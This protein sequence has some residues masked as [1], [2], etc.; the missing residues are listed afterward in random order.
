MDETTRDHRSALTA[1]L[2]AAGG[3]G[4]AFAAAVCCSLPLTLGALGIAGGAWMLD[5]A[6]VVGPWQRALLWSATALLFGA[7]MVG[8]CRVAGASGP[9]C[10][11][12]IL[13]AGLTASIVAGI[14][15]VWLSLTVG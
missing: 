8:M 10:T 9:V 13:R 14:G 15:F 11:S 3:V 1:I 5:V 6:F 12:A 2:L 4:A 7:V